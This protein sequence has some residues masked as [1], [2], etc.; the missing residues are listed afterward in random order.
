MKRS[1]M[2]G[3]ASS[4]LVL[5][6]TSIAHSEI[7]A[8]L[9]YESKPEQPVRKE[10]LAIIDVDPASSGFGKIL[11]DIPLPSDLVAHHIV[12]N[13]DVSKAYITALGK[14]V[15]HVLDMKRFPYRVKA[16]GIPDCRVLEDLVLSEDNRTWYLTCMGCNN[17]IIGDAITDKPIKTVAAS[18]SNAFISHP[19]GISIHNGIDRVRAGQPRSSRRNHYRS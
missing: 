19:H 15:L 1:R 17:I 14:S 4:L 7:L 6:M 3:L 2:Y 11:M 18:Q 12:Y 10:G 16:I 9:N 13:R 5:L 8:M